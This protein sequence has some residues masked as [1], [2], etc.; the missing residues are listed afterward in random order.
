MDFVRRDFRTPSSKAAGGPNEQL[1]F[2]KDGHLEF[3]PDDPDNPRDYS[4]GRNC[5]ITAVA[6]SLVMI[7]TFASSA[8]SGSFEGVSEDLHVSTEAAGLVTTLF[9]LG[10]CAGPFFWVPLSK[11]LWPSLECGRRRTA[12]DWHCH[13]RVYRGTGTVHQ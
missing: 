9:L 2:A 13:W 5:Y 1:F 3:G 10:Y 6:I 11:I 12:I 4:F 8:L 7:A